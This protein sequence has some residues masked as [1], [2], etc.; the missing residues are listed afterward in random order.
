MGSGSK[1]AVVLYGKQAGNNFELPTE[2]RRIYSVDR[3]VSCLK[4]LWSLR[5]GD[6]TLGSFCSQT[7]FQNKKLVDPTTPDLLS[8]RTSSAQDCRMEWTVIS[9]DR[10]RRFVDV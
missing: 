2:S 7:I 6:D 1:L 4:P 10:R 5:T 8:G 3:F 9:A